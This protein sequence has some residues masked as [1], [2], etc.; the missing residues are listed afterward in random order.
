LPVRDETFRYLGDPNPKVLWS[1]I[2]EFTILSN[3]SVRFQFDAVWDFKI[4]NWNAR[5]SRNTL[6]GWNTELEKE[7]KGEVAYGY[8]ARISSAMG[9]FIEDASFCKLRELSISYSMRNELIKSLGINSVQFNLI[10]RNLFTITPYSGY[11]PEVNA[12]GQDVILRGWDFAVTPIP[13]TILFGL[14]INL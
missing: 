9:E 8:N 11:D 1:L 7:Y 12:A 13:R 2:N 14:N 10:G 6:Y 3:L 5:S 4:F